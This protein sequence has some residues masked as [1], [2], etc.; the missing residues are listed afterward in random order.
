MQMVSGRA[1]PVVRPALVAAIELRVLRG[2]FLRAARPQ[3]EASA[4][5]RAAVKVGAAKHA[6]DYAG[7]AEPPEGAPHIRQ[8]E[9]EDTAALHLARDRLQRAKR[10]GGHEAD[11]VEHRDV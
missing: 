1:E 9:H 10:I 5:A 7:R 8:R 11:A 3:E 2:A 6:R 4:P